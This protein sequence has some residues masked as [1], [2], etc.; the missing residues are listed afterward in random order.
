MM[1]RRGLRRTNICYRYPDWRKMIMTL[2]LHSQFCYILRHSR[3]ARYCNW[4]QRA[5]NW[6]PPGCPP[7][8]YFSSLDPLPVPVRP[9]QNFR[10]GCGATWPGQTRPPSPVPWWSPSRALPRPSCTCLYRKW[11]MWTRKCWMSSACVGERPLFLWWGWRHWCCC[12]RRRPRPSRHWIQQRA[13]CSWKPRRCPLMTSLLPVHSPC[14]PETESIAGS[15]R[16]VLVINLECP[17]D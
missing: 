10:F 8:R 11:L 1:N 16:A 14:L 7:S 13:C 2:M 9:G 4:T 5:R 15:L 6:N 17:Q 3:S 12:C